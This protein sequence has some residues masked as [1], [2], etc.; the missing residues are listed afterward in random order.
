ATMHGSANAT[1]YVV[2]NG[3]NVVIP[4]GQSSVTHVVK[5]RGDTDV[6]TDEHFALNVLSATNARVIDGQGAAT[7]AND[8]ATPTL[9][10]DDVTIDEGNSGTRP[11]QFVVRLS[12]PSAAPVVFDFHTHE[13]AAGPTA[14]SPVV[15]YDLPTH[16]D[17]TI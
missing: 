15:D 7:I 9:S 17:V 10:M 5:V 1:D 13:Y 11:A 2:Q 3:A 4:I 12:A 16:I 6:E 14:A 8:E